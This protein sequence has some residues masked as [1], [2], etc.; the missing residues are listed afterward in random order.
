MIF[1]PKRGDVQQHQ[2]VEGGERASGEGFH[3][4]LL[5]PRPK[6]GCDRAAARLA[7]TLLYTA[8]PSLTHAASRAKDWPSWARQARARAQWVAGAAF[9]SGTTSF[10]GASSATREKPPVVLGGTPHT[11]STCCSGKAPRKSRAR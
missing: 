7:R 6:T 5:Q 3:D 10:A 4:T 9:A 11:S 8:R 1:H 2:H